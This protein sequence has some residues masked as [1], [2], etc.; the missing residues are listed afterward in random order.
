MRHGV[1]VLWSGV[2]LLAAA[3]A[4]HKSLTVNDTEGRSF[5]YTPGKA[6]SLGELTS[7]SAPARPP[8]GRRVVR[9]GFVLTKESRYVGVCDGYDDGA[10]H[11]VLSTN[12]SRCRPLTCTSAAQCPPVVCGDGPEVT[13]CL[14]GLCGC[15]KDPMTAGDVR[16]LCLAGTGPPLVP[17]TP[18]Q[19]VREQEAIQACEPTCTVPADCRKP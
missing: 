4:C 5:T 9:L 6:D 12:D 13:G 3:P 16:L 18:L 19:E 10:S 14:N 11:G 8:L 7:S 2:V 17:D 15:A 1:L